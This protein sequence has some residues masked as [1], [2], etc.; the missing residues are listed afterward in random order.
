MHATLAL[1]EQQQ[2]QRQAAIASASAPRAA[3]QAG[4]EAVVTGAWAPTREELRSVPSA[5]EERRFHEA[6]GKADDA[7]L[8]KAFRINFEGW[9]LKQLKPREWLKD[10]II[11][12]YIALLRERA[13][14]CG[15]HVWIAN[16]RFWATMTQDGRDPD[17]GA[18][19]EEGYNYLGIKT[20]TSVSTRQKPRA[21]QVDI[22]S[23]R[24]L[25]IPIN[26]VG[27]HWAMTA[28]DL[29]RREVV[30]Y[31]S[32]PGSPAAAQGK[33]ESIAPTLLRW[34]RDEH[35]TKKGSAFDTCGWTVRAAP[36]SLP[37]QENGF[38]CGVFTCVYLD[39]VSAGFCPV[40]GSPSTG[41]DFSQADMPMIRVRIGT[42]LL[43]QKLPEVPWDALTEQGLGPRSAGAK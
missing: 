23:K 21:T 1:S 24:L 11:N 8:Y 43:Q 30:Y 19:L 29:V 13:A 35:Q 40:S 9:Q 20:H 3:A 17:T 41:G 6:L 18:L 27:S 15:G 16:T 34:L 39:Y 5:E 36:M 32:L 22:F 12:G 33:A 38:D 37:R 28:V 14:L 26:Y 2:E 4:A 31:D 42:A 25:L 7:F 10:D